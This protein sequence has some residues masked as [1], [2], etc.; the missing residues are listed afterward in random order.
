LNDLSELKKVEKID[1]NFNIEIK[2]NLENLNEDVY[3]MQ[4]D[5]GAV[6]TNRLFKN[7]IEIIQ[8]NA[9]GDDIPVT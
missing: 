3:S 9:T 5:S 1:H 7:D 8:P 6:D 4:I 2:K